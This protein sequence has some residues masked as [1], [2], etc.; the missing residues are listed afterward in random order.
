MKA[1]TI[2]DVL[3]TRPRAASRQRLLWLLLGL[4]LIALIGLVGRFVNGGAPTR[5][6]TVNVG[7]EDLRAEVAGTGTLQPSG[8]QVAGAREAGR[9][10]TVRVQAR[11]RVRKGQLL[12][13]LDPTP[14]EEDIARAAT[15]LDT[16]QAALA[17]VQVT[18]NDQRGPVGHLSAGA[19]RIRRA[20]AIRAEM[21][22]ADEDLR[23]ATA[24]LQAAV[25]EVDA[26][27]GASQTRRR[28]S[29]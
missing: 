23:K 15:L 17:G 22:M 11:Q 13:Q 3:G 10:A 26:A 28:A 20:G 7:R 19:R 1:S 6:A 9:I 27:R 4:V 24:A 12:A 5:Y 8:V 21:A 16:R 18:V 2:D 14:V 25:L 29:P